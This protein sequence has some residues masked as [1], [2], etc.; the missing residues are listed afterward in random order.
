MQSTSAITNE[1]A[2]LATQEPLEY[3]LG[4]G[5]R[6]GD[7]LSQHRSTNFSIVIV[8]QTG[9]R[10]VLADVGI[11]ATR[12]YQHRTNTGSVQFLP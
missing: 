4:T 7:H 2:L 11:D 12:M 5:F 8:L 6:S 10:R 9:Q 1:Q 3:F